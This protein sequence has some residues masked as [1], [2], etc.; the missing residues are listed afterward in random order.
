[1][2]KK[3]ILVAGAAG[4]IPSTLSEFYLKQG[5]EVIGLDNFIT[6][7]RSNVEILNQYKNFKFYECNIYE[8]LPNFKNQK[9]EEI[10]SLASP[11]SPVDFQVLPMEI[12]RVNSEGTMH[13]LDLAMEKKA[14][15]LEAS[16]SEV[17]GDPEIH[18]QTEEYF[19][20]VNTIGPRSCYDESKRYAE[21][22]TMNY[23]V[24]R[25]VNTRIVRI[26]NTYGPRM[27]PNDGRVIP[28]FINQALRGEDL[29]VYGD[30]SQTRSFCFV[31]DLVCA[32]DIVMNS[33]C[34]TPVN[35]GN[36]DEYSIY[37]CAQKIIEV[38]HSKSKVVCNNNLPKDD[39]K[40][41]KPDISKLKS[42]APYEPQVS[43][44]E[45]MKKTAEY[46]KHLAL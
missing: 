19:G 11:A 35:I 24:H 22:L 17:Y 31:D 2:D 34:H 8:S 45:G 37:E 30:G 5:H 14:K 44:S 40:K 10:F 26:F 41:R 15:F 36:P 32:M 18:P 33:N 12:L 7:S 46:F 39:P 29:I 23:H 16:T 3:V 13:L 4:F 25:N 9:I 38:L 20:N 1:M 28:N 27:R 43:F 6:G 42:L 21:A